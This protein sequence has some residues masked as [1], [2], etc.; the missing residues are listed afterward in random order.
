MN[1]EIR[2]YDRQLGF[3][4]PSGNQ[5]RNNPRR[6]EM[7]ADNEVGVKI[8]NELDQGPGVEA[9]NHVPHGVGPPR[10]VAGSVPPA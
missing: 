5:M 4:N 10:L 1:V 7:G 8:P 9:I 6:H 2:H 3:Q